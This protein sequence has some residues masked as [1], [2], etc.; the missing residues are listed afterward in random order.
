[1]AP[2]RPARAAL[3]RSPANRARPPFLFSR[4]RFAATVILASVLTAGVT[5]GSTLPAAA[6]TPSV[7][8]SADA[9]VMPSDAV[10]GTGGGFN[11]LSCPAAGWCVAIGQYD[12]NV[13]PLEPPE[14]M[15]IMES[16]AGFTSIQAPLPPDASATD[17]YVFLNDVVC[18]DVGDCVVLGTYTNTSSSTGLFVDTLSAG[19][20]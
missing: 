17:P 6:S 13:S 14:G 7:T 1:M 16:S 9:A 2:H 20:W 15:I 5:V 8:W 11:A 12:S 10:Q 18:Q 4:G 19:T 3:C